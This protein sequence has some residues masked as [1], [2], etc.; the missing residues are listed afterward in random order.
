MDNLSYI[1]IFDLIIILFSCFPENFTHD[2][3]LKDVLICLRYSNLNFEKYTLHF[4][5]IYGILPIV[6]ICTILISFKMY[7]H[8]FVKP[9]Q[10]SYLLT[11][12]L[13]ISSLII[14]LCVTDFILNMHVALTSLDLDIDSGYFYI[15]KIFNRLIS[16]TINVIIF[17]LT[18]LCAEIIIAFRLNSIPL[19]NYYILKRN[20]YCLFSVIFF[21]VFYTCIFI[22]FI[23]PMYGY[24]KSMTLIL[25]ILNTSIFS[26]AIT[27]MIF[28]YVYLDHVNS[29]ILQH[30]RIY[31]NFVE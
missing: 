1:F 31:R 28:F 13:Y 25:I 2:K 29:Y 30:S 4:L 21:V 8:D 19:R 15:F 3:N 9:I 14:N 16:L 23:I 7:T 11:V 17:I 24:L 5:T 18:F 12:F 10:R 6:L 22:K 20:N 26:V 27:N